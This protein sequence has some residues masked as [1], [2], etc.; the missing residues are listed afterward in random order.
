MEIR[1]IE[2]DWAAEVLLTPQNDESG[3]INC[4]AFVDGKSK[5]TALQGAVKVRE[6]F[7]AGREAYLRVDA[8]AASETS[9]DTKKTKHIG[10]VRFS[11]RCESGEWHYPEKSD[12]IQFAGFGSLESRA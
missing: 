8:G 1:I 4:V 7:A 9:F 10:F 6:L 3:F 5:E 11:F 12:T 2:I